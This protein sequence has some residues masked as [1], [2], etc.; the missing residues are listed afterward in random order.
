MRRLVIY[1]VKYWF[2]LLAGFFFS[3]SAFT[4]DNKKDIEAELRMILQLETDIKALK[5]DTVKMTKIA[6]QNADTL[7]KLNTAYNVNKLSI[8]R[9]GWPKQLKEY[10]GLTDSLQEIRN[11]NGNLRLQ[12]EEKRKTLERE[13][14]NKRNYTTEIVAANVL[15]N[16]AV[17]EAK[18]IDMFLTKTK[19]EEALLQQRKENVNDIEKE[20]KKLEEYL[21]LQ[22]NEEVSVL[23]K[24]IVVNLDEIQVLE[25]REAELKQLKIDGV[26]LNSLRPIKNYF[27]TIQALENALS[28]KYSAEQVNKAREKKNLLNVNTNSSNQMN[29][30]AKLMEL[31]INYCMKWKEFY[32][33]I[34][35][36]S[37]FANDEPLFNGRAKAV[38]DKLKVD[39]SF[40]NYPFIQSEIK[41][42]EKRYNL[43]GGGFNDYQEKTI[44]KCN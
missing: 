8:V 21:T 18:R 35:N 37:K 19:K 12:N 24:K 9:K 7:K 31:A 33:Q 43:K 13:A 30:A 27:E 20:N 44:P 2:F 38:I 32:E 28:D 4:Q 36:V 25:K 40:E 11:Y 17:E 5:A 42:L 41:R 10:V 6:K 23:Q 16:K 34:A 3:G 26:V 22:F 39:K 29:H 1:K 15:R 14:N